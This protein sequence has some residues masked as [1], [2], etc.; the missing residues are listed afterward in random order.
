MA[1]RSGTPMILAILLL[2]VAHLACGSPA[3]DYVLRG[4]TVTPSVVAQPS[5]TPF[6]VKETVVVAHQETVVVV[7]HVTPTPG[8]LC[9][10]A[11]EA[12][13]L[14]PSPSTDN[15]PIVPLLSREEVLDLGGRSGTWIFAQ[16]RD[17]Q[18]WV[19]GKYVGEC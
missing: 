2:V 18:G 10:V 17:K 14:R 6:V 12:V 3:P 5:Q 19:Q 1:K 7:A 8:R 11:Q 9:V 4:W 15:H 13:Y 16:V